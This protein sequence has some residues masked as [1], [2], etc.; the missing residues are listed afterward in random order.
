M[1]SNGT[2]RGAETAFRRA[3]ALTLTNHPDVRAYYSHFLNIMRRPE[4]AMAQIE[5]ALQLDPFNPLCRAL[6]AMDLNFVHRYDDAVAALRD[7]LRTAPNDPIPRSAF[8]SAP[9]P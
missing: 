3:I 6:Y 7:L 8:R 5:R 4:E 1:D 2:G 9:A